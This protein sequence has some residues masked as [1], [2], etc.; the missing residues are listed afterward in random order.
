MPCVDVIAAGGSGVGG[1]AR[2][3]GVFLAG[4][5]GGGVGVFTAHAVLDHMEVAVAAEQIV[6][7]VVGQIKRGDVVGAVDG[8]GDGLGHAPAGLGVGDVD[9]EGLGH[10]LAEGEVVDGIAVRACFAGI[11]VVER[12][13]VGA[14]RAEGQGAVGGGVGIDNVPGAGGSGSG[15]SGGGAAVGQARILRARRGS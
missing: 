5:S 7:I 14:V 1:M 10:G 11:L 3:G 9:G 6:E 4:I 15:H 8:D 12:V 2:E 13:L